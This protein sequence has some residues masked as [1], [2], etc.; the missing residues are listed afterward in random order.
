MVLLS[1][2]S[3]LSEDDP[4]SSSSYCPL[5]TVVN[6][7]SRFGIGRFYNASTERDVRARD[8]DAK[9]KIRMYFAHIVNGV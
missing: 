7:I 4:S 5:C 3:L 8:Q 1:F 2:C 6:Q 9:S